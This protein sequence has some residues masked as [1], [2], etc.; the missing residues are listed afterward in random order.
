VGTGELLGVI[1]IAD[2]G[3]ADVEDGSAVAVPVVEGDAGEDRVKDVVS[4]AT[5]DEKDAVDA[6]W[7]DADVEGAV[8]DWGDA[9]VEGAE[10][11]GDVGGRKNGPML[12]EVAVDVG[13]GTVETPVDEEIPT[14][15][16][17]V[18]PIVVVDED[19]ARGVVC[20]AELA[21]DGVEVKRDEEVVEEVVDSGDV[22][23]VVGPSEVVGGCE[24]VV[25]EGKTVEVSTAVDAEAAIEVEV[26]VAIVGG[27]EVKGMVE[28]E[29]DTEDVDEGILDE[30]TP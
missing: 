26:V 15:V 21:T 30:Q 18:M 2:E 24:L 1:P 23:V 25:C 9:D 3:V 6:V 17:D 29:V 22:V 5:V 10:D 11:V 4:E 16:V 19:L 12:A 14:G 20:V 8:D 13:E 28:V 7:G 27:V